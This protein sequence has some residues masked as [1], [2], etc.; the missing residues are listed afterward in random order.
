MTHTFPSSPSGLP[1]PIVTGQEMRDQH[2]M[3]LAD[4]MPQIVWTANPDGWLDY[5]NRHWFEYTGL[6]IEETQGWGWEAVL[7]PEDLQA[8]INAWTNAYTTGQPYEVEYRFKRASDGSYRWHLGRALPVRDA[9]GKITKWFG[10][11][12]DIHEQKEAYVEVE[13][14]VRQRTADLAATN[15]RLLSEIEE[16]ERLAKTQERD[17]VRL[18]EIIVTQCQLA[19]AALDLE[20]FMK[21]VV[22]RMDSLTAASGTVV[23]L[24]DG[25]DMVYRASSGVAAS[26]I[27]L[28]LKRDTSISGLCVKSG[29][30]LRCDDTRTDSRVDR[31]ACD[32]I[33]IRSLIV[34]PLVHDGRAVGVLKSMA[35]APRAFGARDLQTLQLMAGL[36]GSAIAH[37]VAFQAKERLLDELSTAVTR[38]RAVEH[39]TQVIVGNSLDAFVGIDALGTITDWNNAAERTF[40]WSRDEAIGRNLTDTIIPA[41][42]RDAHQRGMHHYLQTGEASVINRRIELPAIS[43]DGVEFPVEVT[44]SAFEINGERFFGA[45][46]HDISDRK[47]AAEQLEEKQQLLDAVLETIDVGVIACSSDGELTLFNRAAREFHGL[48]ARATLPDQW[49]QQYDLF[50]GDGITP[51][52]K[53]DIPLFRALQGEIVDGAE[54]AIRP[55][56]QPAKFFLAS[57]RPLLGPNGK[58]LGAVVAMQDVSEQRETQHQLAA[59]AQRLHAITENLPIF[60]SHIDKNENFL[61]LNKRAERFYGRDPASLLGK[62]VRSALIYSDY[63]AIEPHIRSALNGRKVSF[64]SDGVVNGK[65][66]HYHTVYI[67]D[68]GPTGEVE[69]AYAMAFDITDRK[70]SELRQAESEERLRTITDN[71]PVLISYIDSSERYQFANA[72]YEEWLGVR[73]EAM[74]GQSVRDVL[75]D[76]QYLARKEYLQR[77]LSGEHI[78]FEMG[79]TI[80]G[81]AR[82]VESIYIPHIRNARVEGIYT[83]STDV[84]SA[85]EVEMQ[86]GLL[87]RSDALTGLPNRRSFE[88]KL[89]EAALRNRR[90]GR[91]LALMYL[92]IDHFKAINDT[93]GHAIG[94]E[95]LGEFARRVELAVR[96]TDTVARLGGDEFTI[97]L[98][99]IHNSAEAERVAAKVL[100]SIRR[101]FLLAKKSL[102][103]KT[104]I[105]VAFLSAEQTDLIALS[106]RSDDAL[107]KAK[108][109]GRDRFWADAE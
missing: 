35:E 78:R 79:A 3:A 73:A 7:H 77:A 32:R 22:Y 95:V 67:P 72:Q 105:G 107:Y 43:R 4:A 102:L 13:E 11:C 41:A 81:K 36:I 75:G 109:A 31:A 29:E 89:S 74:G 6:T 65:R 63:R 42:F 90:S 45:F 103:V 104:S 54:M 40:G 10:T 85:K 8:C 39:R 2:A 61:F 14:R 50:A 47:R 5:Y 34:A 9:D 91:R 52:E 59:N 66:H 17:S 70:N 94:D 51:L 53:N 25:D 44:I 60:I 16:R 33:G 24:V 58:N 71:L 30:V 82:I 28:R 15:A 83:L 62:S 23:E 84:T 93:F 26:S 88:E 57:G 97:I 108:T 86:L 100:Q 49:A 48:P 19:A 21:L 20:A 69:G 87:A 18:N 56:T 80:G 92:D 37:Q 46:L 106:K 55:K 98:E 76:T 27:G 12:T 64:E 96:S 38:L 101:P 99:G 68:M 1:I